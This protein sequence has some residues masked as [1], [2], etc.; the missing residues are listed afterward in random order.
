MID[1]A[2]ERLATAISALIAR[3]TIGREGSAYD[4]LPLTDAAVVSFIV[5]AAAAGRELIQKEVG[6]ASACPRRT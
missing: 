3:F 1:K 6:D 2:G 5:N 4:G